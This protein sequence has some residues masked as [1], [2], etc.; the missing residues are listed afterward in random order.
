VGD[1]FSVVAPSPA[2]LANNALLTEN[3]TQQMLEP[4]DIFGFELF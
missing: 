1:K 3:S 4:V 2:S